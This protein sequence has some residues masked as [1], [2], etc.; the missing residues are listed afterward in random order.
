MIAAAGQLGGNGTSL[1]TAAVAGMKR[2]NQLYDPRAG[3]AVVLFT[4]G[5]NED[6]GGPT[7]AATVAELK[8]LYDPAKPVRLICIGLGPGAD[9]GALK[10]MAAVAGGAAYPTLEP[11]VLPKVLF[12]T[13]SRRDG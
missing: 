12:E 6:A 10:Q 3:N 11:S 1:Y 9:L 2:M 4:D 8:R 13:M 7:L 5:A